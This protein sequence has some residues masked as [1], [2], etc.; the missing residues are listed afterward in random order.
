MGQAIAATPGRFNRAGHKPL[1]LTPSKLARACQ[2]GAVLRLHFV[3]TD[4][5]SLEC[6]IGPE[7]FGHIAP[8]LR[9]YVA[10]QREAVA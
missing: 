5:I 1:K 7:C 2:R 9:T 3:L 6:G 10:R 4:P 8:E